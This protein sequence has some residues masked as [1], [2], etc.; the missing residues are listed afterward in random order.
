MAVSRSFAQSFGR[1]HSVGVIVAANA[2][3]IERSAQ[4]LVYRDAERF[5]ADIPKRLVDGRHRRAHYR[6]RAVEAV[7]VHGLPDVLDLHRVGAD[8]ELLEVLDA[9]HG[10]AGLAF[11]GALAPS[12]DP[13]VGLELAEDVGPVGSGC[14]RDAEHLHAGDLQTRLKPLESGERGLRLA[15]AELLRRESTTAVHR[16]ALRGAALS[17]REAGRAQCQ[18]R[19]TP[20]DIS[21]VPIHSPEC[22]DP[23][24]SE[25]AGNRRAASPGSPETIAARISRSFGSAG[26]GTCWMKKF[27]TLAARCSAAAVATGPP[28]W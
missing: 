14:Q 13:L 10:C 28:S 16:R 18:K 4:E 2:A 17:E 19:S 7:D 25:A 12:D 27:G 3:R 26:S 22:R 8:H 23:V 21:P 15:A 24:R 11:E 5:A 20:H 6:S 9:G 1:A